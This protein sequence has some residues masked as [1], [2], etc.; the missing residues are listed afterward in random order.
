MPVIRAEGDDVSDDRK[1][2]CSYCDMP[3]ILIMEGMGMKD[4]DEDITPICCPYDGTKN[5][6]YWKEVTE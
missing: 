1:F 4:E 3:C 5:K 6:S 2:M